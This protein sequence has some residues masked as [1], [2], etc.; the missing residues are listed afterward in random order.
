MAAASYQSAG[1]SGGVTRPITAWR[2][3][4]STLGTSSRW[5]PPLHTLSSLRILLLSSHPIR[6][7]APPRRSRSS[8]TSIDCRA[9]PPRLTSRPPYEHGRATSKEASG[10]IPCSWYATPP[11]TP[12]LSPPPPPL[13]LSLPFLTLLSSTDDPPSWLLIVSPQSQGQN[14]VATFR[15]QRFRRISESCCSTIIMPPFEWDFPVY[16]VHKTIGQRVRNYGSN[17]LP[18]LLLS[19]SSRL[20]AGAERCA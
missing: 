8:P 7:S 20:A 19:F 11:P 17:A 1:I 14:G 10:A 9:Q 2:A 13:L 6:L 4:G 16:N 15:S 12:L 5:Y 18:L 3:P